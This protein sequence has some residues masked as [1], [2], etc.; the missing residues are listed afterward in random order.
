MMLVGIGGL[1][2]LERRADRE[3]SAAAEVRL[4]LVFLILLALVAASGLALL[5]LRETAAMGLAL[6]LHLGLVIGF[7]A[8]L[9]VSKAVH[10]VYRSLALLRAAIE[11]ASPRLAAR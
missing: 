10:G 5:A 6:T 9:P 3:P 4:N 7:F 1:L 11:R 2:M 8:V